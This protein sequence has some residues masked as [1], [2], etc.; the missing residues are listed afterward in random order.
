MLSF[1]FLKLY[2][3]LEKVSHFLEPHLPTGGHISTMKGRGKV[4]MFNIKRK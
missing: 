3:L 1:T 2:I 4:I